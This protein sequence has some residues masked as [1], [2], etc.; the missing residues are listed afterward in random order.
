MPGPLST[1]KGDRRHMG[2]P[3]WYVTIHP[4]QLSLAI[5]PW[6]GAV[7]T[8][9]SWGINRQTVQCTSPVVLQCALMSGWRIRKL[10]S[11][12]SCR[13]CGSGR[14]SVSL[15]DIVLGRCARLVPRGLC[16]TKRRT[17]TNHSQLS[18][19]WLLHWLI[20]RLTS[21]LVTCVL[22]LVWLAVSFSVFLLNMSALFVF[23]GVG[24]SSL[25]ECLSN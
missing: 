12:L 4:G 3:S 6:V 14:T 25:N 19:T 5:P 10:R 20:A 18:A 2:K 13:L 15:R 8:S 23:G 11:A 17:S 22:I 1:R 21:A 9:E 24:A 16:W 7:S